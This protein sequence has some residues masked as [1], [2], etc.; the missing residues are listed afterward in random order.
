MSTKHPRRGSC[1]ILSRSLLILLPSPSITFTHSQLRP[2]SYLKLSTIRW[3]NWQPV[4]FIGS[5]SPKGAI[6]SH[7]LLFDHSLSRSPHV[8]DAYGEIGS[9]MS[10]LQLLCLLPATVTKVQTCWLALEHLVLD[11][12]PIYFSSSAT[13]PFSPGTTAAKPCG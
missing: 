9:I 1:Y 4:I 6:M 13:I 8:T 7:F 12:V 2:F 5:L 11:T 10:V 3:G